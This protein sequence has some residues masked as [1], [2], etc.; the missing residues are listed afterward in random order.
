MSF[1]R[2]KKEKKKVIK[3]IKIAIPND[4]DGEED[5]DDDSNTKKGN[6]DPEKKEKKQKFVNINKTLIENIMKDDKQ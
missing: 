6:N 2:P 1:L 5:D 4:D 3:E